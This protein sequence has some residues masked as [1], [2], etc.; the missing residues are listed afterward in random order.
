M[1]SDSHL[2]CYS[3]F[4]VVSYH[5]IYPLF[6]KFFLPNSYPTSLSA[7]VL[8]ESTPVICYAEYHE[9]DSTVT[10]VYILCR[11]VDSNIEITCNYDHDHDHDPCKNISD[12]YLY[13]R[14]LVLGSQSQ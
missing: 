11:G 9:E 7:V 1:L 2:I 12:T 5:T 3:F 14:S 6:C 10:L 4:E 13:Y 8:P